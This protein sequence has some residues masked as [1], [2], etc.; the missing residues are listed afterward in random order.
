M[1]SDYVQGDQPTRHGRPA[2]P[3]QVRYE[4][5]PINPQPIRMIP[6]TF[7]GTSSWREYLCQYERISRI[8]GWNEEQK[9]NYLWASLMDHALS[10]VTSLAAERTESYSELCR[11]M[12][13]RFGDEHLSEFFKSE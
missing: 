2:T 4:L 9:L 12:E 10:Y 7:A 13:E 3:P 11:A 1:D 5:P 8:N 6:K